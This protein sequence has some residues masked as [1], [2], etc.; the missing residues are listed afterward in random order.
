MTRRKEQGC[1]CVEME[2]SAMAAVAQFRKKEIFQFFHAA[3]SLDGEAWDRR[4]L[5]SDVRFTEKDRFAQ[6]ALEL[7]VR[8]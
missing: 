1:I 7:A 6:L 8:I 5:S 4:S 2:C 3:D